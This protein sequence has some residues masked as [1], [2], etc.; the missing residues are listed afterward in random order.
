MNDHMEPSFWGM[1]LYNSG[2]FLFAIILSI[3]IGID[4][5]TMVMG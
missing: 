1:A 2:P 4:P 3:S 5:M